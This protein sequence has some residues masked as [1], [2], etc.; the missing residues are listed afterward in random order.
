MVMVH[1]GVF[2]VSVGV[3][4]RGTQLLFG[5]YFGC[6]SLN[7]EIKEPLNSL[8]WRGLK[9]GKNDDRFR[10]GKEKS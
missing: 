9:S 5:T 10:R 2:S 4:I 1:L 3:K 8:S 6:L 7:W